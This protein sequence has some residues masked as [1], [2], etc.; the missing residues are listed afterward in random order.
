MPT[1][2]KNRDVSH[3]PMTLLKPAFMVF[4]RLDKYL[5]AIYILY[6]QQ[7]ITF[8]DVH[9]YEILLFQPKFPLMG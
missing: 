1:P 2:A 5:L 4:R 6:I 9:P 3:I 7:S 8:A